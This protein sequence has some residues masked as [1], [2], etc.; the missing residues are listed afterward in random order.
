MNAPVRS[1]HLIP[2]GDICDFVEV[3]DDNGWFYANGWITLQRAVDNL[4]H[5]AELWGLVDD[6][7]Q[8]AIQNVIAYNGTIEPP[9]LSEYE[10]GYIQRI[11]TQWEAADDARPRAAAT[12][13]EREPYRPARST[14]AA[15]R[16]LVATGD[17]VRLK[18]W[19]ADRG[20][21]APLLL[22]LLESPASC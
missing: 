4:Q 5:L 10:I 21:D 9:G 22:A 18:A 3:C 8:D 15:F 6:I 13:I 20:K 19:L 17:V 2:L 7:G 1:S 14:E 11:I 12:A 16:Y